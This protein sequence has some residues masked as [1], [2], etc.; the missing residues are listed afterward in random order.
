VLQHPNL[1]GGVAVQSIWLDSQIENSLK[2]MF[3]N[4]DQQPMRIYL[5]WGLYD[6]RSYVEGWTLKRENEKFDE[7]LRERGYRP[8]GG[9]THDSYGWASWRNRT[10]RWLAALF[11]ATKS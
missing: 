2:G 10:D 9:E 8:A 1:F 7:Y 4:A 3:R 11:P 6:A 5:D